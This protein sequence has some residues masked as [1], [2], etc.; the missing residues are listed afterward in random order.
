MEELRIKNKE[1]Y[2]SENYPFTDIPK[3]TDK[4]VCI[5]CNS[6]ITVGEYKVFK[7]ESGFEYI[8]CP[9]APHCNGTVIDWINNNRKNL[10]T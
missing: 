6:V 2:L 10:Q 3:L 9:T 1:K 4:K 5:N 7:S 8:C